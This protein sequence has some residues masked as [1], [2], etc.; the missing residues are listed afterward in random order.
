MAEITPDVAENMAAFARSQGVDTSGPFII[1][2]NDV[3]MRVE[4]TELTVVEP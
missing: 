2:I 3:T 1:T 4:G